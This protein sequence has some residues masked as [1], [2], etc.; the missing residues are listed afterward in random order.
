MFSGSA[1]TERVDVVPLGAHCHG[2]LHRFD[3]SILSDRFQK[4]LKVVSPFER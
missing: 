4:I 3:L 2:E 1:G